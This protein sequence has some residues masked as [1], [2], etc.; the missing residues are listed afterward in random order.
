[1]LD[2]TGYFVCTAH[3]AREGDELEIQQESRKSSC[4]I[5]AKQDYVCR[6]ADMAGSLPVD[7]AL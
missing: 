2:E 7:E 5:L 6:L 1:M 4:E 3:M